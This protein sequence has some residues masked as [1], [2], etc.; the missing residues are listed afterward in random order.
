MARRSRSSL[1]CG[2]GLLAVALLTAGLLTGCGDS[3]IKLPDVA[4]LAG[5]APF[6]EISYR[7]EGI[8]LYVPEDWAVLSH[9]PPLL[10]V[11]TS[12][13][14]VIALWR[15]RRTSG[16]ALGSVSLSAARQALLG[17][18]RRRSPGLSLIRSAFIT[19][20]GHGAVVLDTMQH[21]G[22]ALRQDRSIH[23]YLP[24]SEVV[25][26]EYAPPSLFHSV[27]HTVF[28]PVR[29]SLHIFNSA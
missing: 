28:S 18:A 11:I 6:R 15:Y 17:A 29:R 3:R 24:H 13:S 7:R 21:M 19:V 23:V 20:D 8:R 22:G 9:R 10:G 14:A 16:V 12:G 27:D 2:V 4:R 25:L 26:E 5:P 1:Q